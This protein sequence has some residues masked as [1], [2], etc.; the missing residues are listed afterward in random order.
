M[1]GG[2]MIIIMNSSDM[3]AFMEREKKIIITKHFI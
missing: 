2:V 3:Y 1:N